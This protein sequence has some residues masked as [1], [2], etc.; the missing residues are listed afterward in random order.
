MTPPADLVTLTLP[1][2]AKAD[3]LADQIL[4]AADPR[5]RLRRRAVSARD[6]RPVLMAMQAARRGT[7]LFHDLRPDD[8]ADVLATTRAYLAAPQ[9]WIADARPCG[10]LRFCLLYRV[11]FPA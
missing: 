6:G 2:G 5:I 8:L 11:P 3:P 9:G 10:R 7:Y 1:P 4:R